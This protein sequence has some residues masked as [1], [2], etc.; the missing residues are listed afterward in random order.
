MNRVSDHLFIDILKWPNTVVI[1]LLISNLLFKL[2]ETF[3][4]VLF[5]WFHEK[6]CFCFKTIIFS[7]LFFKS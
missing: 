5:N 1:D 7:H 6:S 4:V 3:Y 2:Q